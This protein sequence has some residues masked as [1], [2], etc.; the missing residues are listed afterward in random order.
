MNTTRY[1]IPAMVLVSGLFAT[2]A[3][4][5]SAASVVDERLKAY[6][7]EGAGPFSAEAGASMWQKEFNPKAGKPARSCTTCHGSNLKKAGKHQRTKKAIKPMSPAANSERLTDSKKVEKWFKRNCK[8]TV[9][10]LCTPQEK[11]DFLLYIK[12]N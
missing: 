7:T 2:L 8:W 9:G 10:R 1:L 12:A 5:A 11:G 3:T 6:Q 4:P